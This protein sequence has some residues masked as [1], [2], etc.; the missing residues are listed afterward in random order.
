MLAS[1]VGAGVKPPTFEAAFTTRGEPTNAHYRV[2]YGP[3][4]AP[5]HLEV[6]RHGETRVK[7]VTDGAIEVQAV[8]HPGRDD[9]EMMVLDKRRRTLTSVNRT[10]LYRI[11]DFTD[12]FD[13]T[14]GL[15]HPRGA[16]RVAFVGTPKGVPAAGRPCRWIEMDQGARKT[17]ICWSAS[18]G[19]PWLIVNDA[20]A[21]V[22]KITSFDDRKIAASAFH[23]DPR[24]Y[25]RVDA[26]Q[27]ISAD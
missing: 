21:V 14:H 24:S 7:R 17:D 10:N 16:Y 26:D 12:W 22:W 23:V 6:W 13:L 19:L 25:T 15:R 4:M 5:R 8:R 27:D 11:G 3:A 9:F 1:A 20:G 2:V 18:T